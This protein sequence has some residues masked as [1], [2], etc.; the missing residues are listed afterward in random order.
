[1]LR[2]MYPAGPKPEIISKKVRQKLVSENLGT[3]V[4]PRKH[5]FLAFFGQ[6]FYCHCAMEFEQFTID[7]QIPKSKGGSN[8]HGN[9]VA[10]CS[11][12]NTAKGDRMPT[13]EELERANIIRADYA[14]SQ[15][16]K[17]EPSTK[18]VM[19]SN[20]FGITA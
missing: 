6:C 13:S 11:R 9:L 7:H 3:T 19:Y 12:C 20:T 10:A 5:T 18:I 17:V 8:R 15:K 1:M 2:G 14:E 16:S 4:S